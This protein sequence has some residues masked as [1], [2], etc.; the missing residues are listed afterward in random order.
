MQPHGQAVGRP[1]NAACPSHPRWERPRMCPSRCLNTNWS[2][3]TLARRRYPECVNANMITQAMPMFPTDSACAPWVWLWTRSRRR[4]R[5]SSPMAH[6]Q[7]IA[8][9]GRATGDTPPR[10][11]GR[12]STIQRPG[13]TTPLQCLGGHTIRC[14]ATLLIRVEIAAGMMIGPASRARRLIRLWLHR[15]TFDTSWW[16]DA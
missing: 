14:L 6:D 7:R 15:W 9:P 1:S 8:T 2:H 3:G 11:R 4:G 12:H 5:T 13:R 10:R 16:S